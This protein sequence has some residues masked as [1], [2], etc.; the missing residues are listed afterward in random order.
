MGKLAEVPQ[1]K[2]A[3]RVPGKPARK[4]LAGVP[5]TLEEGHLMRC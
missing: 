2:V 5:V 3:G 4:S 1:F